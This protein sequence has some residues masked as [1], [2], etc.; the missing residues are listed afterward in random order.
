MGGDEKMCTFWFNT[1]FVVGL[2]P[3]LSSPRANL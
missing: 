3:R 2:G 1:A